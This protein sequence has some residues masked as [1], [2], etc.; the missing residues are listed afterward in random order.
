MYSTSEMPDRSSFPATGSAEDFVRQGN[1]FGSGRVTGQGARSFEEL[2]ECPDPVVAFEEPDEEAMTGEI[3]AHERGQL[4]CA[5][6]GAATV[7]T[8]GQRWHLRPGQGMWLPAGT[9]HRVENG[10]APIFRSIYLHEDVA[11]KLAL[12]CGTVELW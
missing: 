8:D 10:S 7:E 3:H 1:A 9:D 11:A 6:S 12:Q 2:Q 5:M 4:V